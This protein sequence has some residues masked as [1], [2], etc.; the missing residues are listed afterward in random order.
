MRMIAAEKSEH[1]WVIG[2]NDP[3]REKRPDETNWPQNKDKP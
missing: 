3:N 2:A 1:R